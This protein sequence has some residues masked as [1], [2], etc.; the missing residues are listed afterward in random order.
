MKISDSKYIGITDEGSKVLKM[1]EKKISMKRHQNISK[2]NFYPESYFGSVGERKN[3][4]FIGRRPFSKTRSSRKSNRNSKIE[5][6]PRITEVSEVIFI[7]LQ[8][9]K[10]KKTP[11]IYV[12]SYLYN[13]S[14]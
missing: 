2:P 11:L 7:F 1:A 4:C 10:S 9:G 14:R 3:D 5:E 6:L 12:K 13:S 8:T